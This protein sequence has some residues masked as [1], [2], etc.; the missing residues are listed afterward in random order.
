M[1]TKNVYTCHIIHT[2]VC[3]Y[4]MCIYIYI[5]VHRSQ[6]LPA[7]PFEQLRGEARCQRPGCKVKS[8]LP[9]GEGLEMYIHVYICT[10]VNMC[11]YMSTY[12]YTHTYM[13]CVYIYTNANMCIHIHRKQ[14]SYIYIYIHARTFSWF[15]CASNKFSLL[16][17]C[18]LTTMSRPV[19]T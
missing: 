10:C 5:Q 3:V 13:K 19:S 16:T 1:H 6:P 17:L 2:Y 11:V 8:S 18:I 15:V 4:H 14:M 7:P 12:R 9:V